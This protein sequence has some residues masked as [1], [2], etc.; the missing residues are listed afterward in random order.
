MPCSFVKS[1]GCLVLPLLLSCCAGPQPV[2]PV[3]RGSPLIDFDGH[4]KLAAEAG[5]HRQKRL[6]GWKEFQERA[7]RPLGLYSSRAIILDTRDRSV[8]AA[9]HIKGAVNLPL[10]D[11]DEGNL[12]DLLGR[13]MGGAQTLM[14]PY[15]ERE[16]LLY[17]GD[18]LAGTASTEEAQIPLPL[19]TFI[20]LYGYGYKNVYELGEAVDR[21]LPEVEWVGDKQAQLLVF[22]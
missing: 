3:H 13:D 1:I 4:R 9:G 8:F 21:N 5:A 10:P 12:T 17:D 7:N 18:S 19:Q 15:Y 6:I 22:R 11:F 16:I 14:M 2:L 20:T